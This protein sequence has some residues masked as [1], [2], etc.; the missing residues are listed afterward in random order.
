MAVVPA[1]FGLSNA[2]QDVD[3]AQYADVSRRMLES[4]NWLDLRDM[5]GPFVN[6]PPMMFWAQAICMKVLGVGELAAHLPALLYGVLAVFGTFWAG[7]VLK[8][9]RLGAIAAT[10]V[11]SS[12]A[13]HLMIADPKVDMPLMAFSTLAIAA[14][15]QSRTR[16]RAMWAA[17]VFAACAML[18]KG[19]IGVVLPMLAV[20]PELIRREWHPSASLRARIFSV[21]PLR[22]VLIVA[23][24][25][26][27]FYV[28]LWLHVGPEALHYL[29]WRQSAGKLNGTSGYLNDTTAFFYLHTSLWAFL[30][31][32]P[33]T[34][35]GL[36]RRAIAFA[37]ARALPGD[38]TR[39]V[40]WW[41]VLPMML[42]SA[43]T[44][45]LPQYLYWVTPAAALIA[46]HETLRLSERVARGLIVTTRVLSAIAILMTYGSKMTC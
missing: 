24:L 23:A 43:S 8:D 32:V 3:P 6:K 35:T 40:V 41:L 20:G 7:R 11:A 37:H 29:L 31:F 22:G 44:F 25:V 16:P 21:K 46:A 34:I 15:Y 26:A 42:I 28:A 17:W 39:I 10:F 13:F 1:L 12:V 36:V 19:P 38:P 27:P 2:M 33:L 9:S 45:K 30:P 4:G 5:N 18:S 14:T